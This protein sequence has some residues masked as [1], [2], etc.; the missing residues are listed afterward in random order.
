MQIVSLGV[1][2]GDNP[3]G[4]DICH[5][6]FNTHKM[7]HTSSDIVEKIRHKI[8][9]AVEPFCK[10]IFNIIFCTVWLL[11]GLALFYLIIMPALSFLAEYKLL[12]T[13]ILILV[14]IFWVIRS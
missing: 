5:H 14:W 6:L 7:N 4:H 8:W 12:I 11:L 2:V 10:P 1:V 13:I 3:H 9:K